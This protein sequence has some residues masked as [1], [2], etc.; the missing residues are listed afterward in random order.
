MRSVGRPTSSKAHAT[1]AIM[2]ERPAPAARTAY[3]CTLC[4]LDSNGQYTRYLFLR[5]GGALRGRAPPS[6]D[7]D[8]RKCIRFSSF[9]RLEKIRAVFPRTAMAKLPALGPSFSET[10]L[11]AETAKDQP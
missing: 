4:I 11:K 3:F 1:A 9:N 7:A 8:F 2:T 6:H 10:T 5:M